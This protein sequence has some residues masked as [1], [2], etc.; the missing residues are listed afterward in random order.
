MSGLL[1]KPWFPRF[2]SAISS[3]R[4]PQKPVGAACAT[5]HSAELPHGGTGTDRPLW[6][7]PGASAG[8]VGSLLPGRKGVSVGAWRLSLPTRGVVLPRARQRAGAQ[9]A[10]LPSFPIPSCSMHSPLLPL[11]PS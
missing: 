11:L 2:L 10:A 1:S 3:L 7:D 9:L 4:E 8:L 6:T 5:G